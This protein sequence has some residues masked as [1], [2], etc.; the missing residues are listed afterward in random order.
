MLSS[1]L[2]HV[3]PWRRVEAEAEAE[4]VVAPRPGRPQLPGLPIRPD[5]FALP[6]AAEATAAVAVVLPWPMTHQKYRER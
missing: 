3:R 1:A 4:A 5:R 6:E 2:S